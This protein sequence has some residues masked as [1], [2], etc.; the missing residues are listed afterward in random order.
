[1][2]GSGCGL[3]SLMPAFNWSDWGIPRRVS[4]RIVGVPAVIRAEQHYEHGIFLY[5]TW[6]YSTKYLLVYPIDATQYLYCWLRYRQNLWLFNTAS[7]QVTGYWAVIL[8][9]FWPEHR[10]NWQ[11]FFVFLLSP[12]G[13]CRDSTL[14]RP[15]PF[16]PNQLHSLFINHPDIQH[17]VI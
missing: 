10:V 8:F 12:S 4:V 3:I 1:V 13:T 11:R 16:L 2:E 15:W 7:N 9:D 6:L 14:I 17:C 5:G